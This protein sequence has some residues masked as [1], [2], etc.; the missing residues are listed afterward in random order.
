MSKWFESKN[1]ANYAKT[2]LL[3]AQKRI[4]Q[5]LDIKEEDILASASTSTAT[6]TNNQQLKPTTITTNDEINLT[7]PSPS[8]TNRDKQQLIENS[9]SANKQQT[10]E[11]DFFSSFLNHV[12]NS[13]SNTRSNSPSVVSSS[14]VANLE[15]FNSSNRKINKSKASSSSA[16]TFALVK[17]AEHEAISFD[18]FVNS[19]EQE[20]EETF[21]FSQNDSDNIFNLKSVSASNL[22]AI[23][24]LPVSSSK[25]SLNK[26][27]RTSS[28]SST[29]TSKH[30]HQQQ[31][32]QQ[33]QS[34]QNSQIELEKIEKKNWIQNYVDSDGCN[35][36]IMSEVS[37]VNFISPITQSQTSLQPHLLTQSQ[38]I[39]EDDSNKTV[40]SETTNSK[41]YFL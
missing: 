4:D 32:Q 29:K 3:E 35:S 33:Q 9:S 25:P 21:Q 30:H 36:G 7:S 2:A 20:K 40:I 16:P 22:V 11:G 15:D 24:P 8:I 12:N 38:P 39:I 10:A 17:P 13:N 18:S 19:N 31:Q 26:L 1:L 6:N 28:S 34:Q 5:V 27:G 41:L 23:E 37:S 14:N